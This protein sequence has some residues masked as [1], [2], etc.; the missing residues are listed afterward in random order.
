MKRLFLQLQKDE[1]DAIK[2]GGVVR[3]PFNAHWIRRL[4]YSAK[5]T[6]PAD[7]CDVLDREICR[8]CFRKSSDWVCY[9]FDTVLIRNGFR[10]SLWNVDSVYYDAKSFCVKVKGRLSENITSIKENG[11]K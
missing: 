1:Y 11:T 10:Q 2:K 8:K 9:P 7:K 5:T 6:I 3:I 4:C